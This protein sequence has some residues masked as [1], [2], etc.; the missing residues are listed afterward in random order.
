M[1]RYLVA[2]H[3][4]RP[5]GPYGVSVPDLPGC[6]AVEDTLPAALESAREAI[7]GWIELAAE[8]GA[9]VPPPSIAIDPEGGRAAIVAVPEVRIPPPRGGS[10]AQT[11]AMEGP[12]RVGRE[13]KGV[14]TA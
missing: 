7:A 8:H 4:D 2:I 5:D 14:E 13:S 1:T 12:G 3:Q 10:G 11:M 6:I 9:P